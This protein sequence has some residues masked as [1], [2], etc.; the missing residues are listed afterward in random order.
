MLPINSTCVTYVYY[1]IKLI[2]SDTINYIYTLN[3]TYNEVTFIKK[4]GYNEGKPL[5]QIYLFTYKYT[6]LYEKLP[7]MKQNLC[8][9]LIVIGGVKC[10]I[11]T[12]YKV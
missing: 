2:K 8:I 5:H 3:S 11:Y 7:I 9:F 10:T 1:G 4:I 6:V 12:I